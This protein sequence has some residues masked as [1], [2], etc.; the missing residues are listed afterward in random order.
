MEVYAGVLSFRWEQGELSVRLVL[1]VVV[2][3][4]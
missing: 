3:F 4:R 1:R 2:V